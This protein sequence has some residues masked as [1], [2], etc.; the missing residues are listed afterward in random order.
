MPYL[1]KCLHKFPV[2][3]KQEKD[4]SVVHHKIIIHL[5]TFEVQA[6][7]ILT[8]NCTAEVSFISDLQLSKIRKE[9]KFSSMTQLGFDKRQY[10]QPMSK[11]K[12]GKTMKVIENREEECNNLPKQAFK[13]QPRMLESH[14]K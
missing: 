11:N 9:R 5:P 8:Y 2:S 6:S 7:L 13:L 4:I 10:S 3:H 1:Q 12:P 14:T